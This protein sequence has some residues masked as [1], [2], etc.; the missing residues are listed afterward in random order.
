MK[1]TAC[2]LLAPIIMTVLTF[3][4]VTVFIHALDNIVLLFT[5]EAFAEVIKQF[6]SA[7]VGFPFVIPLVSGLCAAYPVYR[8]SSMR[9]SFRVLTVILL[10]LLFIATLA[11][12][13]WFVSFNG[14]GVSVIVKILIKLFSG[15]VID[16]LF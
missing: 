5:S 15:G 2:I 16:E 3:A 8:F 1:K 11:F 9:M 13:L 7:A 12:T 4:A 14:I 10:I 6:E